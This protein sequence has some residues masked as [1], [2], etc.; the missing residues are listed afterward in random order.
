MKEIL[1]AIAVLVL[2]ACS[3][4]TYEGHPDG[5]TIVSGF[6]LGTNTALSGVAVAIDSKGNRSLSIDG[7]SKDQVE[8][9]KQVNQGLALVAEGLAKGVT[10]G[11]S[12][13]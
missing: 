6:E 2:T 7:L 1:I 13:P 9:M 11:V 5:S 12:I 4:V 8:G 10:K 3:Y